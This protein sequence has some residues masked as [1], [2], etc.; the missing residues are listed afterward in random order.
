MDD[1]QIGK[2]CSFT[3]LDWATNGVHPEEAQIQ[4]VVN[5]D[6]PTPQLLTTIAADPSTVSLM[7]PGIPRDP[8]GD[9][10]VEEV[11]SSTTQKMLELAAGVSQIAGDA[12][13]RLLPD[14]AE[15]NMNLPL[16]GGANLQ[17]TK[18]LDVLGGFNIFGFFG[19]DIER[20]QGPRNWRGGLS[21]G[22][23]YFV[24]AEG[25]TQEERINA[26]S[27]LDWNIAVGNV[28]AVVPAL[29]GGGP[30]AIMI[31]GPKSY[32]VNTTA[33]THLFNIKDVFNKVWT[34]LK[35]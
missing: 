21:A 1:C 4:E 11:I 5:V 20:A 10:L 28:T 29:E 6:P 23:A 8:Y 27:G 19:G 33:S 25:M 2:T 12:M 18:N 31:G 30:P 32:G 17:V 22:V 7:F 16:M 14:Y 15:I 9:N 24:Q 26:V 34:E 35:K 13:F 3:T